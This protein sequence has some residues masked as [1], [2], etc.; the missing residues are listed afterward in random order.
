MKD[1]S[2][3]SRQQNSNGSVLFVPDATLIGLHSPS[4]SLGTRS[5]EF[6]NICSVQGQRCEYSS[7]LIRPWIAVLIVLATAIIVGHSLF[8]M[9]GGYKTIGNAGNVSDWTSG[10]Y[11]Y[12]CQ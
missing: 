7:C 9:G 12:I 5:I 6:G 10:A 1:S 11:S 8:F 2:L 3:R 4:K